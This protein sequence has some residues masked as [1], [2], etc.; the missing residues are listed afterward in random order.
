MNTR[1]DSIDH[2]DGT[3]G[4]ESMKED[5]PIYSTN[6]YQVLFYNG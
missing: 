5:R 6:V 1:R 4:L 3:E 2:Q